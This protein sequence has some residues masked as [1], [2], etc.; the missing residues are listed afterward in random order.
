MRFLLDEDVNPAAAEIS[1]GLGLDAISVHEIDRRGYTDPEQLRFAIS[2]GRV[3]VTRNRD[4]FVRLTISWFQT[5]ELHAGVLIVPR[6]L[7]NHRPDRIAHSLKRWR[8][9]A[10]DPGLHF[11][12]FLAP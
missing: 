6:S 2:E 5:R 8:E 10:G 12:A 11:I 3:L 7:P 4:D 1:R 9:G